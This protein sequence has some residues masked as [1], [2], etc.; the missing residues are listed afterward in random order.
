MNMTYRST[1]GPQFSNGERPPDTPYIR[2]F[3]E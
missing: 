1:R 2:G 3:A